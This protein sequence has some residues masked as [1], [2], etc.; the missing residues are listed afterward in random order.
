MKQPEI[1]ENPEHNIYES[2]THMNLK[3]TC[4]VVNL[5]MSLNHKWV[6]GEWLKI[7]SP[8]KIRQL[9]LP[10]VG[11]INDRCELLGNQN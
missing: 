8:N 1:P 10:R 4:I 5:L 9:K 7:A 3:H 6:C 2:K 11:I